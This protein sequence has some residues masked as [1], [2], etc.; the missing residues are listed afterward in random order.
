MAAVTNIME[1]RTAASVKATAR[2]QISAKYKA[3]AVNGKSFDSVLDKANSAPSSEPTS[4]SAS[5][6]SNTPKEASSRTPAS[7][8]EPRAAAAEVDSRAKDPIEAAVS[9]VMKGSSR[10][11]EAEQEQGAAYEEEEEV[12]ASQTAAPVNLMTLM[13]LDATEVQNAIEVAEEKPA[14]Q[15]ASV[16]NLQ[17]LMSLLPQSVNNKEQNLLKQL[18]GSIWQEPVAEEGNQAGVDVKNSGKSQVNN[19]LQLGGNY[20][21]IKVEEA[22]SPLEQVQTQ[23]VMT[24]E[25]QP[26]LTQVQTQ[27]VMTQEQQ[28]ILTQEQTQPVSYKAVQQAAVVTSETPEVAA[29]QVPVE[30]TGKEQGAQALGVNAVNVGREASQVQVTPTEQGNEAQN[31]SSQQQKN[32]Q[33]ETQTPLKAAGAGA[34]AEEVATPQVQTSTESFSAQLGIS[35]VNNTPTAAAQVIEPQAGAALNQDFNIPTQIVEQARM[36]KLPGTTEMVIQLK[37]EHLGELTLRVSVTSNGAVNASFH[38]DNAQVRAIIE[39][40]LVQLKQELA[41]Q[42]LKVDNVQVYAGLSDGSS[43]MNGRGQQSWQNRGQ[44]GRVN[45][46]VNA[47]VLEEASEAT[48]VNES[49]TE[50]GVDYKV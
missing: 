17:N 7:V 31:Q 23:P 46:R 33:P 50:E 15:A 29:V 40:S 26:I 43:L 45:G 25:Q 36:I 12:F 13:V 37:P 18:S 48:Q 3:G 32:P 6:A 11:A 5:P 19:L 28:P 2:G 14:G 10:K 1:M 22:A 30:A 39:N 41:N 47:V 49:A 9:A 24:Q 44:N 35:G 42:G 4:S 16:G 21:A 27:P 20:V 34:N 8:S 38:S